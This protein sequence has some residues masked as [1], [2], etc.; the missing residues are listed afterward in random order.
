MTIATEHR[1][2]L[3]SHLHDELARHEHAIR[4]ARQEYGACTK[5]T[6]PWWKLQVILHD[7]KCA[8]ERIHAGL[9]GLGERE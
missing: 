8:T 5:L 2:L 3:V 9:W 1:L 4:C 7:H 6:A